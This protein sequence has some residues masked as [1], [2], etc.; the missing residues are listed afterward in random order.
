MP[1]LHQPPTGTVTFLFTD[2]EG[3]TRRWEAHRQTMHAAFVRQEA[4]LR[5]AIAANGGY[6]YKM[7]GDAFQAAF[8][9]APQAIQ[10]AIDA[11]RALHSEK[12][13][14]ETGDVRVRMA[15]HTGTTEERGD[16]YV[17]PALNRVARLLSAGHGGQTLL[18]EVT[19]GL[20]R[21]ALPP[22][23]TLLDMGE[24]HLKDLIRPEHIFQLVVPGLPSDFPPLNTLDN[25]PNNLPLQPTPLV[26]REKEVADLGRMLGRGEVR[27]ITLTGPGGTGKTRLGLQLASELLDDYQNGAWFV[28]LSPLMDSGLVLPTIASVL[29]VTEAGGGQSI[30]DTLVE[31]LKGKTTLLM[32]D[33]FEQVMGAAKEVSALIAACPN[34]KV[35][36]TSRIPLHIRGEKEYLVPPLSTPDMRHLH[37][38][39][40]LE[41][42]TQYGA[43]RLFIERATDVKPDFEVTNDNA[44]AVAEICVRLDGLPLAIELAAARVKM[45]PP[46]VLL[47]RLSSRLKLLIGGAKDLPERQQTL[48]AAIEWSYDL[49][50]E[51]EKQLFWRMAP[52]NGGRT[53]EALEAVCNYDGRY[54]G[55]LREDVLEGVQSL[56]DKSLLQQR[57]DHGEPRFWMLETIHE[58]AREKL[59]ESGEAA[60]LRRAH[61]LYFMKLAE[62]AEPH[63]MGKDQQE[64]FDRLEEEYDNIRAALYW[65]R[66]SKSGEERQRRMER[67][68]AMETE[69]G[70]GVAEDED[71]QV[72]ASQ[73]V[74]EVE[75][76]LRIAGGIGRF[77]NV[78]GYYS[79]GRE[80]LRA[81]LELQK[82]V[83][84]QVQVQ[85]QEAQTRANRTNRTNR[86]EPRGPGPGGKG[87]QTPVAH[88]AYAN[89]MARGGNNGENTDYKEYKATR[90]K[91]LS[92]EGV[93][94]ERQGDYV[95]ARPLFDE[96]LALFRELGDK[97]GIALSLNNLGN[98]FHEEGD[99]S[100]ARSMY[101]ECLAIRRELGDKLGIAV[102]LTNL[103]IVAVDQGDYA[104]ARS[105]YEESLAIE[106]EVG[107]KHAIAVSLHNLGL[108]ALEEGNYALACSL[109]EESLAIAQELGDKPGIVYVL[110]GLGEVEVGS[111]GSGG[112]VGATG[113]GGAGET[114]VIRSTS[115]L[116]KGA[117]LLGAVEALLESIGTVLWAEERRPYELGVAQVRTQLGEKEFEKA[118]EEGRALSM[119]QAIQY[120]LEGN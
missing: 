66:E 106:R 74:P 59:A 54:D 93:M 46:H 57:E 36:A 21:D 70:L 47:A 90:A 75:V 120:A 94:A 77:W 18:S 26:G 113:S 68:R 62:Q 33:N 28:D 35:L 84:A 5:H 38:L 51:G 81:L 10:A 105:L 22:G 37:H 110:A 119:E 55:Q 48:H 2:I 61:A 25:R 31:H 115:R 100:S 43:V 71:R 45:L 15:L 24:H 118:W 34:L 80:Q 42:L 23:V 41:R 114:G 76:G 53:L 97:W 6:A 98:V 9:T 72:E 14:V 101:E 104:L 67:E 27:L 1:G 63:L 79:E 69:A 96:S 56:L 20:V 19:C 16:D 103:G 17:G 88:V 30:I 102:S 85:V 108:V 44:P 4:I 29:G 117:R 91:A 86:I 32:L 112:Q 11:Q 78:R 116:R 58:Y 65:A 109:Y 83:R 39:P 99:H 52:F 73:A 82:V 60:V 92:W 111:G 13:P 64:W 8:L 50:S 89:N 12:W 3:S 87:Q 107:D 49:L 40:P 7:I 95:S